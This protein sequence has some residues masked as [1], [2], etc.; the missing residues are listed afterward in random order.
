MDEGAEA[1]PFL[2]F[3]LALYAVVIPIDPARCKISNI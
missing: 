3:L 1:V 2:H